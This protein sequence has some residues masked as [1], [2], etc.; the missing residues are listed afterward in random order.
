MCISIVPKTPKNNKDHINTKNDYGYLT[1]V[2]VAPTVNIWDE[3]KE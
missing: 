3:V 2:N 1:V